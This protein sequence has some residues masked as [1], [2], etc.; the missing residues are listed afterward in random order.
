MVSKIFIAIG[1][2]VAVLAFSITLENVSKISRNRERI[3]NLE[4]VLETK[5]DIPDIEDIT[6]A[7]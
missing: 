4:R 3:T 1:F 6:D 7:R 5:Q 2:W